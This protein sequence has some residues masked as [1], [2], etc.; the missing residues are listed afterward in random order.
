MTEP[1]EAIPGEDAASSSLSYTAATR[2][3]APISAAERDLPTVVA[4]PYFKVD[5]E[6]K[7]L[8]GPAFD[9]RGNLL[10]VEIYGGR[11]LRLSAGRQ[12]STVYAEAN[13]NPSGIAIHKDGRIFV[14]AC[15]ARN[16]DGYFDAGSVIALDDHGSQRRTIVPSSAGHVPNDIVFDGDGG[17]YMSDF[18]GNSTH[19]AGGVFYLAAGDDSIRPVLPRMCAANGVALGPNGKVLWATEFAAGRLHRA[20]LSAPGVVAQSGSSIPY[21]F[22][23][24][25]PDSMRTDVDGNVYVAMNRQG[26]ILVFSPYGIPI[27]Q[28]L[29]P[30]R[31]K[32]HFLRCTSLALA[33]GSR[34]LLIVARDEVG[35]GG[36]MIFKSKGL[37]DGLTLY[38]HQ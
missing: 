37:A 26:R 7:A 20:E 9:R 1:A 5:D 10:F 8:E 32:N 17:C 13:L 24:P 4:A 15:G 2:G 35:G 30:G 25:G 33:P 29:L 14:A 19:P 6:P 22:I 23:G 36:T 12:L 38:S 21:H 11:V 31:E 3:W 34:D 16:T 28:I 18:R 27:G